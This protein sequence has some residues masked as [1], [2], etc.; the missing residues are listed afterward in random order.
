MRKFVIGLLAFIGF[1]TLSG[2]QKTASPTYLKPP[3]TQN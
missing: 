3:Y 2:C 1:L